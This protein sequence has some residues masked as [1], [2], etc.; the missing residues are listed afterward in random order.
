MQHRELTEGQIQLQLTSNPGVAIDLTQWCSA[1]RFA[2]VLDQLVTW[3]LQPSRLAVTVK[4]LPQQHALQPPASID[5]EPEPELMDM[6]PG[7]KQVE[8]IAPA[9]LPAATSQCISS[10]VEA[11]AFKENGRFLPPFW[12]WQ[13][14]T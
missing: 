1:A 10:I 9:S 7:P 8:V 6:D 2:D 14:P 13:L 5:G 11:G 3:Q 4:Q 12:T